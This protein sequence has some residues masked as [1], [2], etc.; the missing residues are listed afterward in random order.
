MDEIL[1]QS[2]AIGVL[3]AA[4]GTGRTHHAY[5]FHGPVGVGKYTTALAFAKVLLCH[6][7]ETDLAGNI[8]AC[9]GCDSCRAM[10]SQSHPDLHL[11]AK[12]RAADSDN[13]NLRSRKQMNIPIDLLRELVVG[14]ETGDKK[15]REAPAYRS[16]L[17]QHNKVFIIDEAELMD[18]P[19][20]NVLLKTL[21]EPA[22]GTFFILVTANE[23]DLLITIRSRCQRVAFTPLPDE[24][25][26]DYLAEH[27]PDLIE[28][29]RLWLIQFSAGSLGRVQLALEYNLMVWAEAVLPALRKMEKG[30][31]PIGLGQEMADGQEEFAKR[32][33]DEH[34]GA[35]KE[36]ANKRAGTLMFTL[37]TQFA[38]AELARAA[39][40]CDPADPVA[41]DARLLPW[42]GVLEAVSE[43]EREINANLRVN[44]VCEHLSS[45]MYRA[46]ASMAP[47][48]GRR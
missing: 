44:L 23:D 14:G 15:F 27:A 3:Q 42:L 19:G 47:A 22:A 6:S 29:H 7:P 10:Q 46:L 18:A 28:R 17:L 33:V 34:P 25:I 13:S 38:R 48:A 32:W 21:E 41:N 24:A 16:P 8:A 31:Y 43:A 4:L 9:G 11:V 30:H 2:R 40:A 5:I 12:E 26:A 37:I 35:S 1:G 20:Q 45:R 39:D 36:A